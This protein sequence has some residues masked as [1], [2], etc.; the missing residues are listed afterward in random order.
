VPRQDNAAIPQYFCSHT[1]SA[2]TQRQRIAN[3]AS[4]QR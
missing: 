4:T 1:A 3:A 2:T